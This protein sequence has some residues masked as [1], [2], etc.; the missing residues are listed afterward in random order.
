MSLIFFAFRALSNITFTLNFVSPIFRNQNIGREKR[1]E[2]ERE[3]WH[4][5]LTA[6]KKRGTASCCVIDT[7]FS[8]LIEECRQVK[9]KFLL[10]MHS[11]KENIPLC[12]YCQ[13]SFA[14]SSNLR[15]HIQIV[16]LKENKWDCSKC[17]KVNL[18]ILIYIFLFLLFF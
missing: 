11:E 16:H 10:S 9:I 5:Q 6:T 13:K 18:E 1:E 14:N 17:G 3:G 4:Q 8:F 12:Q 15:H 7:S 2:R